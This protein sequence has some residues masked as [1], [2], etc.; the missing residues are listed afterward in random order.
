MGQFSFQ[1]QRKKVKSFSCF[2]LFALRGRLLH[3]WDSPGKSTGVGCHFLLQMIYLTQGLNPD[4]PHCR[5]MLY[6]LSHQ[7][8]PIPK[9]GNAKKCSKSC[10]I[11]FI[12]HASKVLLKILQVRLQQYMNPELPDAQAAFKKAEDM[13]K[14]NTVL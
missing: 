3:P 2:R 6:H 9:K 12:S 1:S 5:K 8:S 10:T 7:G 14:T 13:A 4:L 11:A